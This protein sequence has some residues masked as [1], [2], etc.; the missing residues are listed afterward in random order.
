MEDYKPNF[1]PFATPIRPTHY[2]GENGIEAF[3]VMEAFIGDLNR[4]DSFYWC[5]VVKYILRFQNKN[6]LQDLEKAQYYLQKLV[7]SYNK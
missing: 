4:M 1:E 5:N 2:H 7:D 6:G 3:D